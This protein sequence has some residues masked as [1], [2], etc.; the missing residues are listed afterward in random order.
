[1]DIQTQIAALLKQRQTRLPIVQKEVA[2]W[3]SLIGE[4]GVLNAV[5]DELRNHQ[6]TPS[7]IKQGLA[8]FQTEEI[9]RDIAEAVG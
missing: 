5:V 4:I 1:M 8:G 7:E 9:R 3:E 6:R 2:R